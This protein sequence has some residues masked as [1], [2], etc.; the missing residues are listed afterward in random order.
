MGAALTIIMPTWNKAKYIREALDSVFMQ[1][2][3]YDYRIVVADDCSTD[4]TL[5]IVA[6]YE[7]AYPGVIR[8]LRSD[9]NLKLFRNVIRA[10]AIVKTPYF[11]VLDPDDYWSN[12]LKVQRALDFLESHRDFTV[13]AGNS[14]VV[15]RDGSRPFV[16]VSREVDCDFAGYIAGRG[17]LGQTAGAVYRN[18][19]FAKGLPGKLRGALRPDQEMTFRGDAFRN[20]IHLHEGKAHFDPECDAVYRVTDE[21]LWQGMSECGRQLRNVLLFLNLDEYFDCCHYGLL[22][23]ALVR[24]ASVGDGTA[25]DEEFRRR[26]AVRLSEA[27]EGRRRKLSSRP[28][29]SVLMPAFNHERYVEAAVRSVLEQDWSRVEL[30]VVDDGSTDGTWEVLE[31]LRPEC[32]ATL[33][34][35]VMVRQE[36]RG[37]TVTCNRL[38]E[39]S[40]GEHVL[41]L[42]SDDSLL[43]GALAALAAPLDGLPEVGVAVGQNELMDDEGRRCFWDDARNVVYDPAAR[44]ET[45][46]D[47]IRWKRGIVENGPD[48]GSYAALLKANHVPNGALVRRSLLAQVLPF[49]KEAPL[50]DYW[51]H[52]QLAKITRY[53]AVPAHTFRYRWHAANTIRQESRMG[54]YF[55]AV[56]AWEERRVE[57][58]RNRRWFDIFRHE[59]WELAHERGLRGVLTVRS[60]RT[61][62]G[63]R[64][65]IVLFGRELVLKGCR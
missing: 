64:R 8:V 24:F 40:R 11:C 38:F 18:V 4:G 3:S 39:M 35:V 20:F 34:R 14:L 55:E 51:L 25:D 16:P 52:L 43:P 13:Y 23:R 59:C 6:E 33:E 19:I 28:L 12:P 57:Q 15:G 62:N 41:I 46:N 49:R 36:N 56:L 61:K 50:E 44:H 47:F 53:V 58:C 7:R 48:Y 22:R 54:S 9:R 21:G 60:Y 30:L 32:E 45:F 65:S 37:T 29:V 42:A 17:V 27:S 63:R 10:Y 1:K 5:D 31:R 26:L 2:T